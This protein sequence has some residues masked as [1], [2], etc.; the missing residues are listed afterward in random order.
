[1]ES[2][3]QGRSMTCGKC[4]AVF[5][6]LVDFVNHRRG[7]DCRNPEDC[8]SDSV[9]ESEDQSDDDDVYSKSYYRAISGDA[10]AGE[11]S[12]SDEEWTP[13]DTSGEDENDDDVASSQDEDDELWAPSDPSSVSKMKGGKPFQCKECGKTFDWS[14][15]LRRHFFIHTGERP[16]KCASCDYGTT[17][18]GNLTRHRR[19]MHKDEDPIQC[20]LCFIAFTNL[21]DQKQHEK[22]ECDHHLARRKNEKKKK[23]D[24]N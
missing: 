10:D 2:K 17:E 24:G 13:S 4:C 6:D 11:M 7:N 14:A 21:Q 12:D 22:I 23:E 5:T 8:G 9:S 15:Q 19:K 3:G 18:M 16:F 20:Q 1:M